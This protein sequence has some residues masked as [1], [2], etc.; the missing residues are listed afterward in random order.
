MTPFL[1]RSLRR[2]FRPIGSGSILLPREDE[3]EQAPPCEPIQP[4]C[5]PPNH[6]LTLPFD[7]RRER[8]VASGNG[9]QARFS[10]YY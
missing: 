5:V 4:T 10:L 6:A 7:G 1:D 2:L 3:R 8:A 9:V